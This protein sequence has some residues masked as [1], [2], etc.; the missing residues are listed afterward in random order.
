VVKFAFE[1]KD[2]WNNNT[3]IPNINRRCKTGREQNTK[4]AVPM[5]WWN[6]ELK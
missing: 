2:N 1:M 6:S 4:R 3:L 5:M